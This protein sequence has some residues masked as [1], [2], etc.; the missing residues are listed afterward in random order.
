MECIIKANK[1]QLENV[2]IDY[3]ITE[4]KGYVTHK[5]PTGF[6]EVEVTHKVN[7]NEFTN[8]FD[9]P[10]TMLELI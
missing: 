3:D 1:R 2:G 8:V 5:Y 9:I 4:L 10:K 6:Y 7:G